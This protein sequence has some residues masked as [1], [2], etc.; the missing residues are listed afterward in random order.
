MTITPRSWLGYF[1]IV[2][3]FFI[4]IAITIGTANFVLGQ[5]ATFKKD[6]TRRVNKVIYPRLPRVMNSAIINS[7]QGGGHTVFIRHTKKEKFA[8][9]GAFDEASM[10]KEI[11]TPTNFKKGGCLKPIGKTEAWLIGEAFKQLNIPVGNIYASP[12][13]RTLETAQL[14]FGHID[15]VD[16]NLYYQDL[17][18]GTKESQ[19]KLK[20][21]VLNILKKAPTSGKNKIIVA[22]GGMIHLL[23][24]PNSDVVESGMF[25]V[26]H[27][28]ENQLEVVT[29]IDLNTFIRAMRL[30]LADN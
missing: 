28:A 24:W 26:K 18:Q 29:E 16:N 27:T 21:N 8:N 11:V 10:I 17:K 23:G 2:I 4:F 20:T 30:E 5:W 1:F 9:I 22:H 15:F 13:C 6:T 12:T 25:I 7:L 19:E 3:G 14:A